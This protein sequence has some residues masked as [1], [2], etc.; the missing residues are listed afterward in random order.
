MTRPREV[1]PDQY[2]LITRRCSERRYLLTPDDE[3]NNAIAYCLADAS[4]RF[5]VV[6]MMTTV[7][8]NHHHTVIYDRHGQF[9]RFIE[10]F[11]KMV[12]KCV[13]AYRNRRENLWA[14]GETCVTRLVDYHSIL[15]KLAYTAANPVKDMLVERA[16]QWPG[17]TGYPYLIH[18]KTLM[19]RRPRFFFRKDRD[20]PEEIPLTFAIPPE[21]GEHNELIAE[22]VHRVE[23]YEADAAQ[24]RHRSNRRILG[25]KSVREQHWNDS[26]RS[27]EKRRELRPRFAGLQAARIKAYEQYKAFL[28]LYREAREQWLRSGSC[29]FPEGTYWIAQF[30]PLARLTP[31]ASN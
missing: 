30:T 4:R 5:K 26:P 28:G 18:G 9:P 25:R 1:L 17:L 23:Q 21:L 29:C 11:H 8:S 6:V 31:P 20:W 16:T 2:Y 14:S 3:I 22:L 27:E 24:L 13:N 19:T 15:E 7:E 10:H 12:A